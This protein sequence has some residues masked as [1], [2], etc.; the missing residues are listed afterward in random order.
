MVNLSIIIVHY[1]VKKELFKCLK[2]IFDSK[3]QVSFE[4]IVVDND[5]QDNI[6]TDLSNR[7]SKVKYVK[8]QHNLGFGAANNLGAKLA[9]GKYLFFLNPD[10]EIVGNTIDDLYRSIVKSKKTAIV[11]PVLLDENKKEYPLQGTRELTPLRAILNLSFVGKLL[12]L[13]GINQ[14]YYI[15]KSNKDGLRQ[16]DVCP[17]TAFIISKEVFNRV[18]GFDES[19]F[20]YFEEFDLCKRIRHL[21]LNIVIDSNV[22][23]IHRWGA[24]TAQL[25]NRE[26]V[27][28]ASRFNYFKTNFG[29]IKAL[30]TETILRIN[31]F[32]VF[33]AL[34][35]IF[36]FI[37]RTYNLSQSMVFIGDQGWFYLSAR[38]LLLNVHIPLVG[39]TS[40]HTWLHQGP[41]WTYMLSIFLYI[42][43]FNPLSGAYLTAIFGTA[44]VILTY[45]F[46]SEIF[47]KRVGVI[48]ALLY[49]A[50]PLIVYF[51]RMPFDP[52]PIP[53][54]GLLYFYCLFKWVNGNVKYFPLILF[55]IA[56]LYNLELATFTVF[57][58][59]VILLLYGYFRKTSW[60]KKTLNKTVIMMSVIAILVPMAPVIIYDFSHGF[61]QTVVFLGWVIYKPF[62]ILI[63]NQSGNFMHNFGIILKFLLLNLQGMI[64]EY[65]LILSGLIFGLSVIYLLYLCIK[66]LEIRSGNFVLIFLLLI[67]LFG[68]LINQSPSDAYLPII[69]PFA[70][71]TIAIFFDFLLSIKL[72]SY[73]ALVIFCTVIATN[74]YFSYLT[75]QGYELQL[76]SKAVEMIIKLAEGKKYNLIG[77]GEGSQFATFTMNYEYLLWYKGFP[78]ST[79]KT[80]Q[81]ISVSEVNGKIIISKQK[82]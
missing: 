5:D 32:N 77:K 58:A 53:F 8:S 49:A 73:V 76:R 59:F 54:F 36:S 46:G 74:S 3:P 40:S 67:S 51:D 15:H 68:V 43:K 48:A 28:K 70:I 42:F 14:N 21:G 80:A 78:P 34:V 6:S 31:K 29:L 4:V 23:L 30:L 45:K 52:S 19:F 44:T 56:I 61:K 63:N 35:T 20:L 81:T 27:F 26:Q 62:R 37:L 9:K 60:F 57:F 1:K 79:T 7:F 39:I 50:S 25:K 12:S 64:F 38:D 55:L 82:N 16:V 11:A 66:K 18:S 17:G 2:S 13:F 10:T 65:S 71:L 47:S 33:I 41:L 72:L 24:S 69:F 22:K 75:T